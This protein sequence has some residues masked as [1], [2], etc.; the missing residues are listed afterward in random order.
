MTSTLTSA[1]A[2]NNCPAGS[3]DP[4][5]TATVNVLLPGLTIVKSA[6]VTTT[7]P[8][9]VVHYTVTV[10]D[11]GQTALHR[12]HV[13]RP[14]GRGAGLTPPTTATP[15][16]PAA[17]VSYTSPD[18]TWTGNL[19]VG[20]SATIT[21]SVTVNN[22][23]TGDKTLVNTVI[24]ATPGSNCPVTG[25]NRRAVHGDRQRP[26]AGAGHRHVGEHGHRDTRCR[27]GST[28]SRSPTPG[29]TAVHRAPRSPTRW[30]GCW[31]TPPTTATPPPPPAPPPSPAP[32]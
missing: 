24:S 32:S 4:R 25:G 23:D 6:D 10:T 16:R 22:P 3:T 11:T 15:Q 29:P 18:L 8:G 12:R 1:A 26:R 14:A 28:R 7:S 13:H 5:C 30:P 9:A 20:A 19:A 17:R 2:G 31:T 21:Y 27:R